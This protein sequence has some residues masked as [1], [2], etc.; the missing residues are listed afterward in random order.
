MSPTKP[1]QLVKADDVTG[2]RY[3]KSL[4]SSGIYNGTIKVFFKIE[5][6]ISKPDQRFMKV[7]MPGEKNRTYFTGKAPAT[8]TVLPLYSSIQTPTLVAQQRGE[9]WKHPF[10]GIFEPYSGNADNV[11]SAE[12]LSTENKSDLTAVR[13]INKNHTEQIILQSAANKELHSGSN[14]QFRGIFGVVNLK[15]DQLEEM[16]LGSGTEL[17]YGDYTISS[18]NPEA[19]ASIKFSDGKMFVSCNQEVTI[20]AKNKKWKVLAGKSFEIKY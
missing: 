12:I 7:L 18:I 1:D 20:S 11:V 16:Y 5:D 15:D 17:S 14:W 13:V 10:V 4:E 3:I 8:K 6:D 9:A 19:S 2:L